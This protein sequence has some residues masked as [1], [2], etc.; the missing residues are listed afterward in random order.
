[1][2]NKLFKGSD[3]EAFQKEL[4]KSNIDVSKLQKLIDNGVNI[5]QKDKKGR[6]PIFYLVAKKKVDA[7]K[8]LL[9][10]DVDLSIENEYGK[11]VLADAVFRGD[12]M[13]IRYLLDN[14]ASINEKNSSN[15]T[16]LQDTALEGNY[17]IFR[18]L[19]NYE[20]D[21]NLKDS[22]N[23]TV[24]YDAVEGEDENILKDVIENIDNINL[25]D[26][27]NQTVLFKAVLK[28]NTQIAKTLILYDID[29]NI[30]DKDGQTA[31]YNAL[32]RGYD[33]YDVIELLVKKGIDLNITDKENHTVVDEILHI[34]DLQNRSMNNLEGKYTLINKDR[35]YVEILTYLI[36][37][38]L[39]I[40]KFDSNG[41][42][43]LSKAIQKQNYEQIE[44]LLK[45]GANINIQ[46]E[47]GKTVLFREVL[48]GFSNY[49]MVAFLIRNDADAFIKDNDSKSLYDYLIE[50][51]CKF[52]NYTSEIDDPKSKK[53]FLLLKKLISLKPKLNE[54]RPDG[55]N[56]LFE[57]VKHNNFDLIKL[58]LNYGMNPNVIDND[59]NT[60]LSFLVETGLK[61]KIK[62]AREKFIDRLVFLLRFRVDTGIQDKD[63]RTVFH[64]AVIAND[65]EVVEKL[66]TKKANLDAKDNQGRTALHH[67]Q[68]NGNYKIARW[69][70]AAGA[71]MN[72]P[73]KAGFTLLNYAAIFGHVRLVIALIAS[74]VLMYNKNP[75]S[76]KVAQFFKDREKNLQKLLR[77]NISD[78]KMQESLKEV[79][80]NLKKEVD[81]VLKR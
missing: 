51:I 31:I 45:C 8:V 63:G 78:D 34:I 46:D 49:K 5:N 74:G 22:Y 35:S 28:E 55:Q 41:N 29:I 9:D 37:S 65:L 59:G 16:L 44:F 4:S 52:E 13:M 42:T 23:K 57:V 61:L 32:L 20:P 62:D 39:E 36:N 15:R 38:G 70:I 53:Y 25:L 71:N 21:L 6:T 48:R 76:R 17:K 79:A 43:A 3:D 19:M 26:E 18:I 12:G 72:E 1:M 7:V 56:V 73:D 81:A 64:K 68:W 47:Y 10:N 54:K 58:L 75:K 77:S 66:L 2:L 50:K 14:G 11:T 33:N 60:P 69:L 24:L 27:N 30:R 80:I 40:D 67:T